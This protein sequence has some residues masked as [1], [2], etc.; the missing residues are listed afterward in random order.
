MQ[1]GFSR[2]QTPAILNGDSQAAL[3]GIDGE[4]C[5]MRKYHDVVEPEQRIVD[6]RLSGK[7]VESGSTQ[8]PASEGVYQCRLIDKSVQQI[9][10]C[11]RACILAAAKSWVELN[12]RT[13]FRYGVSRVTR[14]HRARQGAGCV[15]CRRQ[16]SRISAEKSDGLE[17]FRDRS[18]L[19]I[20]ETETLRRWRTAR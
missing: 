11:C 18:F 6:E 12:P 10:D 5:D 13:I 17:V 9:K 16:A 20:R 15:G 2:S 8:M 3:Q 14:K 7:H 19:K 4:P 1:E